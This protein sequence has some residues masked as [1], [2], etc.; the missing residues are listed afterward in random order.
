MGSICEP[1]TRATLTLSVRAQTPNRV[2]LRR[3]GM[4]PPAPASR[5]VPLFFASF[6]GLTP[7][8][9]RWAPAPQAQTKVQFQV[10]K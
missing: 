7:Q 9:L 3:G 5:A 6:L 2:L 1:A 4:N 8:A 10:R